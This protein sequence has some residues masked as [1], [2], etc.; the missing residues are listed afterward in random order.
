MCKERL[1]K[2][3]MFYWTPSTPYENDFKSLKLK[4]CS[5]TLEETTYNIESNISLIS[6]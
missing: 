3:A 2:K 6:V 5:P 1:P 4:T